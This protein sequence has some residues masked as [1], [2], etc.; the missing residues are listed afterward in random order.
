M[1]GA[2]ASTLPGAEVQEVLGLVPD[3]A[4]SSISDSFVRSSADPSLLPFQE[5]IHH[6]PNGEDVYRFSSVCP[7]LEVN[8]PDQ[9]QFLRF[10]QSVQIRQRVSAVGVLQ[11]EAVPL[12]GLWV[13]EVQPPFPPA[14]TVAEDVGIVRI[15][16]RQIHPIQ[17]F[18]SGGCRGH[19]VAVWSHQAP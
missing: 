6:L 17:D 7:R 12:L 16:D 11:D 1:L 8:E 13:V 2:S 18:G 5:A 15:A 9:S 3:Q 19:L 14:L 4:E 10:F